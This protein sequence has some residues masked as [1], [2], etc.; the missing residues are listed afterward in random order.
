MALLPPLA[1]RRAARR[2][3]SAGTPV[4]ASKASGELRSSDTNAFHLANDSG[5]QRSAT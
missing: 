2:T 1:Y 4:I 5:S 3:R